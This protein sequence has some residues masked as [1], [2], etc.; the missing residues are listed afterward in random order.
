MSVSTHQKTH[1]T[2]HRLGINAPADL[3]FSMLRDA[4]HWPYLDGLTVYSE[5]VS[6]DDAAHELRTSVVSN[7]SLSS[8]HS[9]RAF[10]AA[11]HRA[12]FHQLD[13]EFPLRELGGDWEIRP[14]DGL[15]VVSLT[16]EFEVDDEHLAGRL[17]AI[18]ED[19]SRRELEA[20]RV[21]CERLSLLLQHHAPQTHPAP[22][23]TP[24][25]TAKE[26]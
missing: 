7:G 12:E 16:H 23:P 21:S 4:S 13:L 3:V 6:G 22:H 24:Q 25:S 14:E 18:I 11:S 10:D 19:Y 20:L 26:A 8:S 2:T 1:R 17:N 15:S 9:W 5:R